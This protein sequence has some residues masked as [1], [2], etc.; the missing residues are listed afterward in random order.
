MERRKW[1]TM[2]IGGGLALASVFGA[3]VTYRAVSAQATTPTPAA[4]SAPNGST[5]QMPGRG[6]H[7]GGYS[8]QDLATALGTTLEK[9]QAAEQTATSE[10]LKQAVADGLITQ[11]QADQFAQRSSNGHPFGGLPFLRD[12]SINYDALLAQ[13]LGVSTDQLQ[14]A[15]QTAAFASLDQAVK[16][17]SLT[18]TQADAEK[19]RYALS[20]ST[21]FQSAMKTA[22]EAAVK[23]AVT[24]GLI[25]QAQADA[26]LSSTNGQMNWGM[27]G[28][29]DGFG[30]R[31]GHGGPGGPGFNGGTF[32]SNPPSN[33]PTAAPSSGSGA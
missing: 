30:G 15:K 23:Q 26:L 8:E 3:V 27:P 20:N 25:T 24:D 22:Y 28:G 2:L 7:G 17:G 6:M 11:S 5:Q 32:P 10:A 12:S 4:P 13:A 19:A 14:A 33:A 31:G 18:Q 1:I 21:K 9:L 29:F 16:D